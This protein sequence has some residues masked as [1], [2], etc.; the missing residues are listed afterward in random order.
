MAMRLRVDKVGCCGCS[1]QA[2]VFKQVAATLCPQQVSEFH[3]RWGDKIVLCRA[4]P[5]GVAASAWES[6]DGERAPMCNTKPVG[7]GVMV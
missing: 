6:S 5:A 1:A 3:R 4:F 7:E 2:R